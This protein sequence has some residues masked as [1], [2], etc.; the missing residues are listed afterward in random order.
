[1]ASDASL[2]AGGADADDGLG[3]GAKRAVPDDHDESA[4]RMRAFATI[5]SE[6][7]TSA[8]SYAT[9]TTMAGLDGG[10]AGPPMAGGW[11]DHAQP[12]PPMYTPEELQRA[13]AA[14]A[15]AA[16]G[17][18]PMGS[19]PIGSLPMGSLPS[20][21]PPPM[22]PPSMQPP[23]DL[24]PAAPLLADP[25]AQYPTSAPPGE[26]RICFPFLNKGVC[27]FGNACRFRHLAE[28]HPDAMADR[29]RTGH[30]AR[31]A[32]VPPG[33]G[34]GMLPGAPS[35]AGGLGAV[36]GEGA[37]ESRICFPFLNRGMCERGEACRFRHLD[38]NHPD[39][40]ADRIRGG[41]RLPPGTNPLAD[42]NPNTPPGETRVCFTFLNKQS[43]DRPGCIFRHLLP[44]HP[45][46]QEGVRNGKPGPLSAMARGGA[47]GMPG[48]MGA[49]GLGAFDPAMMA[50]LMG[51]FDPAM[52]ASMMAMDPSGMGLMGGAAGLNPMM[53]M[54]GN[55]MMAAA[56]GMGLGGGLGVPGMPALGAGLPGAMGGAGLGGAPM[57]HAEAPGETRICFSFLNKGQCDRAGSCRFRH[58]TPDHPDAQADRI[59]ASR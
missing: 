38:P 27:N 30:A 52:M 3:A 24:Q 19:L 50:T 59:R 36:A 40:V 26:T 12:L 13:S 18:M 25:G 15:A 14:A 45:D 32:G 17:S 1:M 31:G 46:A 34:A 53:A 37:P 2:Y 20:M 28:S 56:M 47:A 10:M 29:A 42:Q 8:P 22:Q 4:K 16:M 21:Q 6:P 7:S 5:T 43:C 49:G 58:L 44:G 57:M 33:Q 54:M 35:A 11:Q 41:G 9:T 48:A 51:G 55:P 39:A 23:P